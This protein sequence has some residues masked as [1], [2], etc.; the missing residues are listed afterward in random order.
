M[1][2]SSEVVHS[3]NHPTGSQVNQAGF[4]F[5]QKSWDQQNLIRPHADS[6]TSILS[7]FCIQFMAYKAM[8]HSEVLASHILMIPAIILLIVGQ[9]ENN[10]RVCS[11]MKNNTFSI[12]MLINSSANINHDTTDRPVI[13]LCFII[14]RIFALYS[15]TGFSCIERN[16]EEMEFSS[17]MMLTVYL[18]WTE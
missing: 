2:W 10:S 17:R 15:F 8:S 14:S 7:Y 11:I 9:V 13:V 12:K 3:P 5:L 1:T 4:L 16:V 18:N 6:H